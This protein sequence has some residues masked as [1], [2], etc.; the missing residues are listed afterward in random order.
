MSLPLS[1][2]PTVVYPHTQ[3]L[4]LGQCQCDCACALDIPTVP[5]NLLQS[6]LWVKQSE[7]VSL[8]DMDGWSIL[9]NRA[10]PVGL[11]ALNPAAQMLWTAF[12]QPTTWED[13]FRRLPALPLSALDAAANG[14]AQ[15]GLIRPVDVPA[16]LPLHP[17][18][19][20]AWLHVTETCNLNCSYCYVQ[21]RPNSMTADV[22]RQAVDCLVEMADRQGYRTLKLKYA[23]GEPT[24]SFPVVQ[25]I[26][27]HAARRTE[28]AGLALDE[29]LLSNGVCLRDAMLDF[30][31]E[32]RM[33]LMVS[34]DGGPETHDR[35]RARRDGRSTFAAVVDTVERAMQRGLRPDISITLTSLN[36]EGIADAVAFALERELPF[37]LN[38]YRECQ[39]AADRALSPLAPD[40]A[41]LVETVRQVF[42]VVRRYPAYPLPLAGILDRTRLDVPHHHPCAAG[43]DYVAVDTEGRLSACQ[44]LL[45]DP[46]S[47]LDGADPLRVI[48]RQGASLFEPVEAHGECDSCLWQAACSGGCPLMRQTALHD[49]YCQ[50]YRTLLPE[51]VRLEAA[52][53]VSTQIC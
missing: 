22:G 30:L 42:G 52:R 34:L 8:G 46:W 19:L 26:H 13:A 25:A 27:A 1:P 7:A 53:L 23:G 16:P 18:I 11:A 14:L 38:F 24:L 45:D 9:V 29:V 5:V 49:R 41:R 33:K 6:E 3:H 36:L 20:A 43:R 37:S 15:V 10:G 51:L 31:A 21:K 32:N 35:L 40:P 17:T 47:D 44:M 48:R 50:V 4:H 28:E 12:D 39:P 2:V